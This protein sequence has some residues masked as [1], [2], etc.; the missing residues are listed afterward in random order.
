MFI[1]LNSLGEAVGEVEGAVCQQRPIHRA[2]E[3]KCI[4]GFIL[5]FNYELFTHFKQTIAGLIDDLSSGGVG[6]GD[7]VG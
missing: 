5:L 1:Q 6:C 2:F 7:V 4:H 3:K